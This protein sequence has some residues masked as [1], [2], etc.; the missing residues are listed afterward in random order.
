VEAYSQPYSPEWLAGEY[1]AHL[2]IWRILNEFTQD[3]WR[4]I[5]EASRVERESLSVVQNHLPTAFTL[6]VVPGDSARVAGLFQS[7]KW[8]DYNA[9][10]TQLVVDA[11]VQNIHYHAGRDTL[12][13]QNGVMEFM[14][15][16]YSKY[17]AH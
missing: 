5:S 16:F 2:T 1:R 8:N 14:S 3:Q 12:A 10:L 13:F 4:K 9:L 15:V 7:L 11:N 17:G 6:G